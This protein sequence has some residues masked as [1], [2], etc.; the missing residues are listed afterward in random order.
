MPLEEN[1]AVGTIQEPTPSGQLGQKAGTTR[2]APDLAAV[3]S[4]LTEVW[5]YNDILS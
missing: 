3:T 4:V 2:V 1:P 5:A